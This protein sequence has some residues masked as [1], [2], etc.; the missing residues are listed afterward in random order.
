MVTSVTSYDAT[1]GGS[2]LNH[3]VREYNGFGQLLKEYQEHSGLKDAGTLC[4]RKWGHESGVRPE[5][6][7][8]WLAGKHGAET[9]T[10][11]GFGD[12][13]PSPSTTAGRRR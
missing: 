13:P 3:V 9:G 6:Y 11:L 2:P 7:S 12:R 1:S 5:L 10:Q 4:T 8:L